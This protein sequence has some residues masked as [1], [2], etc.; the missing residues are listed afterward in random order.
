MLPD[1]IH[2]NGNGAQRLAEIIYERLSK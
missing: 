1:G 2:P